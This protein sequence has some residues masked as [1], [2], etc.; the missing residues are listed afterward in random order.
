MILYHGSNIDIEEIDLQHSKPGKD[1]GRGFYLSDNESQA[2]QMANNTTEWAEFVLMN[3]KNSSYN[4]IH[5]YDIVIGP[6]ANDRVGLQ[7]RRFML[8]D[9]TVEQLVRELSYSKGLTIQYF[10]GTDTAIKLLEKK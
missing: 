5:P 10:F 2:M 6:I 9:I 3:R 8:G 7:I 4:P 1:F